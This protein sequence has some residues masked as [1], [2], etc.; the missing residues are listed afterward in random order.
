MLVDYRQAIAD[1]DVYVAV[2]D[3]AI[4]GMVVLSARDAGFMLNNLAVAPDW[5][6]HGIGRALIDFA[7]NQARVHGHDRILLY[8]NEKMTENLALY[9]RLGYIEIAR[10]HEQGYRRIYMQKPLRA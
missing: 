7:E 3:A 8:T 4:L 10:R 1:S 5:Q 6:G 2:R 9:R